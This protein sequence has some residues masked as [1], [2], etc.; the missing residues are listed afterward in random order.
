M[1]PAPATTVVATRV[2]NYALATVRSLVLKAAEGYLPLNTPLALKNWTRTGLDLALQALTG[3]ALAHWQK[4]SDPETLMAT[5]EAHALHDHRGF[6]DALESLKANNAF[7][8][9]IALAID[10]IDNEIKPRSQRIMEAVVWSTIPEEIDI[11]TWARKVGAQFNM[12]AYEV[13][14]MRANAYSRR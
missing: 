10:E 4:N 11:I 7:I 14:A 6:A 9:A 5:I 2:L 13:I 3:Q 1:L 8:S 12:S